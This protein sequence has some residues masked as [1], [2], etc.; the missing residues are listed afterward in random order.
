MASAK[1]FKKIQTQWPQTKGFYTKDE[2]SRLCSCLGYPS[3]LFL[4]CLHATS[5][6]KPFLRG[7]YL[8]C[9]AGRPLKE[10]TI[11]Q[12]LESKY[13]KQSLEK[14]FNRQDAK[15]NI[16]VIRRAMWLLRY[17]KMSYN[18]ISEGRIAFEVYCTEDDNGLLANV[19]TVLSALKMADKVIS[20]LRLNH[21]IQK[22]QHIVDV[23][24]RIQLYEFLNLMLLAIKPADVEE[25]IVSNSTNLEKEQVLDDV[26]LPD[27][28]ELLMT[29]DQK[30]LQFLDKQ[31]KSSIFKEVKPATAESMHAEDILSAAP[32]RDLRMLSQEQFRAFSPSLEFS[33]AQLHQARVRALKLKSSREIAPLSFGQ[34][35]GVPQK[36]FD[37]D[38]L[39]SRCISSKARCRS[40]QKQ[41]FEPKFA[42]I[43]IATSKKSS[44]KEAKDRIFN[45][46]ECIK[47]VFKGQRSTVHFIQQHSSHHNK[48]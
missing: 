45:E 5:E 48:Q 14:I 3:N 44:T 28:D 11:K 31:Y 10:S 15:Y 21:E 35:A 36:D 43:S 40:S 23:P 38:N 19:E 47:S 27:F 1:E 29:S 34:A 6:V 30:V 12:L 18:E 46:K 39:Q 13:L 17:R 37:S 24:S 2:L 41:S 16:K 33:Q 8:K 26:S 42:Q 32:R 20:P 22:Q 4:D 9:L 7:D 25:K